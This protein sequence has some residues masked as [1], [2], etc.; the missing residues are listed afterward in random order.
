[1]GSIW[2]LSVWVQFLPFAPK[3]AEPSED[4]D[5]R[6]AVVVPTV[7]PSVFVCLVRQPL[8]LSCGFRS[9]PVTQGAVGPQRKARLPSDSPHLLPA[10]H[11]SYE[12][13]STLPSPPR[14]YYTGYWSPKGPLRAESLGIW[15]ARDS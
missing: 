9:L 7:G 15:G 3:P 6:E 1:M 8:L 5:R 14:T 4:E 2:A 10:L 12:P 11:D 13:W